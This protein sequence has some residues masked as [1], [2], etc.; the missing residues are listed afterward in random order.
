MPINSDSESITN[1]GQGNKGEI[2]SFCHYQTEPGTSVCRGCGAQRVVNPGPLGKLI[3]Y[4][5]MAC[6]L[7]AL[8]LGGTQKVNGMTAGIIIVLSISIGVF[9]LYKLP[10]SVTWQRK[11]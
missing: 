11:N 10:H 6:V 7:I 5:C 9:A 4:S 8:I 1:P 2:C 3:G